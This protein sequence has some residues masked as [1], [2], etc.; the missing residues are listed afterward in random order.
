MDREAYIIARYPEFAK[1]CAIC[2][3]KFSTKYESRS[4][5]T[6]T[7]SWECSVK[8]TRLSIKERAAAK[9]K[10]EAMTAALHDELA[11][12]TLQA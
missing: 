12:V 2:H 11:C 6:L 10:A 9:A 1:I 4:P 3:R 8:Y 7:C 5:Y